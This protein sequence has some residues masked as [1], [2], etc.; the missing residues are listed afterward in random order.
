MLIA[1]LDSPSCYSFTILALSLSPG[2]AGIFS[3]IYVC[4]Y[5]H[6]RFFLKAFEIVLQIL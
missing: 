1:D 5:T 3:L 2:Q 4:V 6:T